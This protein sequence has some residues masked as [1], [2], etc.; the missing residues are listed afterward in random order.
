MQVLL[1]RKT[2]KHLFELRDQKI[3]TATLTPSP[4]FELQYRS[5]WA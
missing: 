1:Q 2:D 3:K 5:F 4:I